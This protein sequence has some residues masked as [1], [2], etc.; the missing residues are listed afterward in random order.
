MKRHELDVGVGELLRTPATRLAVRRPLPAEAF[1]EL[2]VVD[3]CVDGEIVLDLVFESVL[4]DATESIV[5][6]GTVTAGWRGVCRRCLRQVSGS[7]V[8]DVSDVFARN[9]VDEDAIEFSG[10][11]IDLRPYVREVVALELP[12]APLCED[13][14]AGPD[15]AASEVQIVTGDAPVP[16]QPDPRWSALDRLRTHLGE[17]VER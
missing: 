9:P 6:T 8:I 17:S 1:G 16:T 5:A 12:L 15:G 14:C 2:C 11:T 10:D 13:G 7:V 3:T 4:A